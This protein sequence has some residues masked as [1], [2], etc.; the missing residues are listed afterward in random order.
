V[1]EFLSPDYELNKIQA[2]IISKGFH[3][4]VGPEVDNEICHKSKIVSLNSRLSKI[5]QVY[6]LLHECGHVIALSNKKSRFYKLKS[7]IAETDANFK[8]Y[9]V[10]EE[11]DA[12]NRG[13][14]LAKRL[15][16]SIDDNK[17]ENMFFDAIKKYI[18]WAASK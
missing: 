14:Q 10:E 2:W 6:I 15:R 7:T 9:R 11:I 3:L 5:D 1:E 17:W 16:I 8:V 13:R 4:Y 18:K 12:W